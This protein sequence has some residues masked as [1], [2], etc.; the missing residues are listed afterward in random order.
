MNLTL[1]IHILS[2]DFWEDLNI[3]TKIMKSITSTLK[4]FESD[5]YI[6]LTVYLYFKKVMNQINQID[7]NFSDKLQKF[8]TK[9]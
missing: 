7:C 9:R 2:D 8:I 4:L 6:L 1:R 3:I 5:I